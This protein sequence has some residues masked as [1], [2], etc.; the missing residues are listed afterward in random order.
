[1]I[2]G[3]ANGHDR[4]DIARRNGQAIAG[5]YAMAAASGSAADQAFARQM[6]E[7]HSSYFAGQ[8]SRYLPLPPGIQ[9]LGSS[10]DYHYSTEYGYFLMVE[11][12]R[13][14]DRDNMVIGQGVNRFVANV[15]QNGFTLQIETGDES[16]DE[17]L[18]DAWH[19]WAASPEACDYDGERDFDQI[20]RGLLRNRT[21]DGDVFCLPTTEGSLQVIEN[22]RCRNPFG[23]KTRV[24]NG[25]GIIHG[26]EIQN[27]KRVAFYFTPDELSPTAQV[28]RR[29]R[30][31]RIPARDDEG[32]RQVYQV[33]DPR[34]FSQRRGVTA[35]APIVFPAKYHDDLQFAALVNAKRSSFIAI[36]REFDMDAPKPPDRQAGSRSETTRDDGTTR[37]DEGGAPG[38]TLRGAKGEKIK[39]WAANIPAPQFFQHSAALLGI[40]S[41]NIDLPV[42]VFLLDA[43]ATNFNGYRGVIDQARM[44]FSQIQSD[45]IT[46]FHRPCYRWK[47]RQWI[48]ADQAL[49]RAAARSGI[50]IFGHRWTPRGYP[51]IQP[52]QDAA[53]DDL[54]MA[55]NLIS[56][57]RRAEERGL[58]YD[59]LS[60]EIVED[61]ASMVLKALEAA[62][63]INKQ[64]EDAKVTW[65]DLAYGGDTAVKVS[66]SGTL[67][68]N[69]QADQKQEQPTESTTDKGSRD[70]DKAE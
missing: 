40:I 54:R 51:Y 33:Y 48:Q 34:R 53:A 59:I 41:I 36:V 22:H 58:D 42:M 64:Y 35:F 19:E 10:A 44:R 28:S 23:A 39:P 62:E 16:I 9:A 11:R 14:D 70:D 13:F 18:W 56:P 27:Q 38:Q 61:R 46:Q 6:T 67:D 66:L 50:N 7:V 57:R 32:N 55:K 8:T 21:V 15:V 30:M 3:H 68:D 45:L 4:L 2:N 17:D 24:T 52:V 26:V 69:D 49:R 1:M 47:V 63:Q 5:F 37:T 31:R 65:R 43:S 12:A 20:A 60:T 25:T 29:T